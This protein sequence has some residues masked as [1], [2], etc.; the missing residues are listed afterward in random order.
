MFKI[1]KKQVRPNTSVNFYAPTDA[2]LRAYLLE[3]YIRT[4]KMQVPETVISQDGLEQSTTVLFASEETAREWKND[5][6]VTEKH[7]TPL[8][9]YCAA[10][11][12][13]LQPAIIIGE[14]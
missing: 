2:D 7:H 4:G 6:V 9:A 12:I 8:E 11:G 10:N 13:D 14:V 3:N 1:I 5:P